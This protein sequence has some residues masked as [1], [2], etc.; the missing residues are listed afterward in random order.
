MQFSNPDENIRELGLHP[1]EKIV[2][3]GSG[4]GGH[5]LAAAR[6]MGS[7]GTIYGVD[8]RGNMVEKLKKEVAERHMMNVRIVH[9]T[10]DHPKGTSIGTDTADVVIIPDTLFSHENKPA[11]VEEASRILKPGGRLL[12][13]DWKS[14]YRG[15]GPSPEHVITEESALALAKTAKFILDKKWNAGSYHYAIRFH[16]PSME[17]LKAA[18]SAK[19][20]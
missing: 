17:E 19:S 9:G 14:S 4:A 7:S 1:G 5:T 6:A 18:R 12:V 2:I 11:I 16:K 3:F 15:A 13:V 20:V 8:E 10:V